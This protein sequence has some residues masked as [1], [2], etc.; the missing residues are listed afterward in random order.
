MTT[1]AS[2]EKPKT[3]VELRE[4]LDAKSKQLVAIF[5]EAKDADG[6]MYWDRVKTID[7]DDAAK[8]SEVQRR[9]EEIKDLGGRVQVAQDLDTAEK[10]ARKAAAFSNTPNRPD[11]L[12]GN[13]DAD[14]R[15]AMVKNFGQMVVDLDAVRDYKGG[16]TGPL[17]SLKGYALKDLLGMKLLETWDQHAGSTPAAGFPYEATRNGRMVMTAQRPVQ[18]MDIIPQIQTSQPEIVYMEETVFSNA[19]EGTAQGALAPESNVRY[20]EKRSPIRKI[21]TYMGVTKEQLDDVMGIPM[22]INERGT[23][24]MRQKLDEHLISGDGTNNRLTGFLNVSG[25][26]DLAKD[27]NDPSMS[28]IFKAMTLAR[29]TGRS[30]PNAILLHPND[31]QSIRLIQDANGNYIMGPP[32]L[33]VQNMLWGYPV[34][35][36]DTLTEGTGLVGDFNNF[37]RLYDYQDIEISI[38]DSHSDWFLRGQRAILFD[39]RVGFVVERPA[40]FVR[41]TGL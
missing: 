32:G 9:Q 5:D 18:V 21:A 41:P 30:M 4:E 36:V 14:G 1:P 7:G 3:L 34:V 27:G 15:K 33:M 26:N 23:F 17:S 19:A 38:S 20:E 35:E 2:T 31:W 39:I 12:H 16:G 37:C 29:V 22:L 13:S 40:A 25:V 10:D 24:M 6:R 11:G 8:L 28:T